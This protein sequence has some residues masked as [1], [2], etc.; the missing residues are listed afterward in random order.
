MR[1]VIAAATAAR[2]P[3]PMAVAP[4]NSLS[5][6]A[7]EAVIVVDAGVVVVF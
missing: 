3:P 6:V 7:Y 4:V 2:A 5:A 1:V